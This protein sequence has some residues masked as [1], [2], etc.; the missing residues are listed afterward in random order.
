MTIQI[1]YDSRT[2]DLLIGAGGLQQ[3]F[4]Q[5]RNQNNS[6]SGKIETINQ[7]GRREYAL[8]TYFLTAIY[9][10]L[11]AWWSWVRQGKTWAL[12]MDSGNVGDTTLDGAA[13][14]AQKTVPLT[15]TAAFSADDY[16]LI[17]A[18][19]DDEFEIV[20]IDSVSAGVS[21]AAVENLKFTYAVGD[22]FT[23][24]NYFPEV[25]SLDNSF[26]PKKSGDYY[27]HTFK[28][29]EVK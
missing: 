4:K 17:Q 16:C 10:D 24:L 26:N 22:K 13:A 18:A 28:F 12:A 20:Q 23:H 21:I 9:Y 19:D 27:S 14:A 2:I 29:V 15:A 5:E 6:G 25:I 1:T 8:D 3:I 7:F 11:V